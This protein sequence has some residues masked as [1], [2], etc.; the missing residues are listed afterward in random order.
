MTPA[1]WLKGVL[2][3]LAGVATDRARRA[4]RSE[5]RLSLALETSGMALWELDA[6]SGA[7][8][9]S[10]GA[11]RLLGGGASGSNARL[12]HVLQCLHPDDRAT[13]QAAVAR[14]IANP[15]ESHAVQARSV[16]ADGAVR[17]LEARGRGFVSATGRLEGLRGTLVDVTE[18]KRAEEGFRRSV[19]ELQLLAA[20]ADAVTTAGD[21]QS[22]LE[23]ATTLLR[24]A[25]FPDNCGFLLLDPDAGVLR[26]AASFHAHRGRDGLAPIPL[27]CGIVGAVARSGVPRSV[28]DV[29]G[30]A[31]Y[32]AADPGMRSEICVPL[33][34][35]S[36]VLGVFDAESRRPAAFT[37]D[38][39]RLLTV[40][41]VHVAGALDRLR[42]ESALRESGEL[43]R[44]YFTGSPVA[45]FVSG[46]DGR[47]QEVNGAACALTGFSADELAGMSIA[48][49][50]DEGTPELTERL[51]GM[52]ALGGGPNEVRIRRKD[53]GTRHC[54]VHASVLGPDRL[55]GLLLDISDRREA[56]Q[57]LR[58]SEERFRSLSEASLEAVF[59]HDK[60]RVVDVNQA[61]CDLGGY[62][63][64]ELVGHDVFEI[65]APEYRERV[66]RNLLTEHEGSYEIEAIARD[67]SRRPVE[68][69]GRSFPYRGQILRVVAVRDMT[70][71][72][73]AAALR[74]S[75]VRELEA[76]NVELARLGHA[77]THRLKAPLVTVK[78]FA[79]HLERDAREGRTGRLVQDAR[80]IREA[81]DQLQCLVDELV[82]FSR[83]GR[84][85][86]PPAVTTVDDL[87]GEAL[88]LMRSRR[89]ACSLRLE[90]ARPLP[91]VYGDRARLVQAFHG[92][93]ENALRFAAP[94]RAPSVRVAARPPRDGQVTLVVRDNGLGVRERERLAGP[95]ELEASSERLGVG[96]S[97]VRRVVE[98]HGGRVWLDETDDPVGAT[99]CLTLPLPPD[100]DR[101]VAPATREEGA[102]AR[103]AG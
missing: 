31:D 58:D 63:W 30:T 97:L 74:D 33:V 13:F 52:L 3:A 4:R 75:L 2:R 41:A 68:V 62:S 67:G 5:Q 55:V 103:L 48:E 87:V 18:A 94:E 43:Y 49:L 98:S 81:V 80:R 44:A 17:W 47:Y 36:R 72:K 60:G 10:E 51:L 42:S 61:L 27:G 32:V 83:A 53:G 79:G 91:A 50:L 100:P 59:I 46:T 70:P 78:G 24:D 23:R 86:G 1:G 95:P 26:H 25:F 14:A 45:L 28:D 56:E 101:V 76:K 34:V 35:G 73:Q 92:L 37:A 89:G 19:S 57:R 71:H 12:A 82:A 88:R 20:V 93:L 65:I 9:W 21:E 40:V 8:W 7:M 16:G 38:D 66:Y 6:G 69:Q 96:L 29:L 102:V 39:E 15:G 99:V 64:H 22:L 84:P 85:V 90:L 54:L 77:V 11:G